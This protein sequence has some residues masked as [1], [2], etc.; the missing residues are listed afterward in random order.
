MGDSTSGTVLA[1]FVSTL[2]FPTVCNGNYKQPSPRITQCGSQFKELQSCK[3]ELF[4]Q[5]LYGS[6]TQ[7]LATSLQLVSANSK[8]CKVVVGYCYVQP[9]QEQLLCNVTGM[10]S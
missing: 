10:L 1:L 6:M 2:S 7:R 5:Q 4:M 8:A 3:A 9:H